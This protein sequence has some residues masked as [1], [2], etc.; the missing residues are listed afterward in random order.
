MEIKENIAAARRMPPLLLIRN[1]KILSV[2]IA[3][4]YHAWDVLSVQNNIVT[5]AAVILHIYGGYKWPVNL[6]ASK[7]FNKCKITIT[8]NSPTIDQ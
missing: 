1:F 2:V 5:A 8:T 7:L 6:F 4:S 3:N